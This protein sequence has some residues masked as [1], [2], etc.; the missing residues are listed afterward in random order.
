MVLIHILGSLLVAVG[1]VLFVFTQ[2]KG[3]ADEDATVAVW[4]INMSGPPALVLVLVGTL[5]FVFP[6]T[7]FFENPEDPNPPGATPTTT[8]TEDTSLN[9]PDLTTTTS[10]IPVVG[11]PLTPDSFEVVFDDAC[12]EDTIFWNQ[13][14]IE[15]VAGWWLS[16]ESYN[17][18]TGEVFSAFELDTGADPLFFGNSSAICE[19]DFSQEFA[20]DYSIWIYSYNDAGFSEPLFIEYQDR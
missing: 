18:D 4:K 7:T 3:R 15:N 8:V 6:F 19:T 9:N 10:L 13:P 2:I 20:L 17:V 1:L 5:I 11:L 12:Q 16:F 14:E